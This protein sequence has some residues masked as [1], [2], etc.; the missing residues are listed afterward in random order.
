MTLEEGIIHAEEVV[1]ECERHTYRYPDQLAYKEKFYDAEKCAEEHR[2]LA[3]W[4]KE[5]HWWRS[6]PHYCLTCKHGAT[7]EYSSICI[8]CHGNSN[9]KC[10]YKGGEGE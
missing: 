1:K 7:G 8:S 10:G 5:L 9:W 4:L 6:L 2:Q 3:E